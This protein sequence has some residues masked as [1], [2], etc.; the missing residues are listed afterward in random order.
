MIFY[1]LSFFQISYNI[2]YTAS[3]VANS[4]DDFTV[5]APAYKAIESGYKKQI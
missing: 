1:A 4:T 3:I 5:N 2:L